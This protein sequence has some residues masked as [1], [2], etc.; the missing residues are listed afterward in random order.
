M[1]DLAE[2][3]IR[4]GWL[5]IVAL[6]AQAYV[7][8]SSSDQLE[9]Q[10]PLHA[11]LLIGSYV[12]LMLVVWA[13]RRLFGVSVIGL[14]LVLNLAVMAA[15]GG[16]MPISKQAIQVAGMRPVDTLPAEG[17]RVSRTKDVLLPIEETRL[18][19]LS[20]TITAPFMPVTARVFSAGDLVIALGAF[21][22]FQ[23]AMAPRRH[24]RPRTKRVEQPLRYG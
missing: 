13:N 24:R 20:D 14:G 19:P 4:T 21:V 6:M 11:F 12:A 9:A 10:R 7:V 22:L 15:N 2:V 3:Q 17:A 1:R 23:A 16:F 8:F 5:A 18:Q